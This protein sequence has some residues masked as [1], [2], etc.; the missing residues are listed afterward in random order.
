MI[1]PK[2]NL[3]GFQLSPENQVKM[4]AMRKGHEVST[5]FEMPAYKY[6]R[7]FAGVQATLAAEEA[8]KSKHQDSSKADLWSKDVMGLGTA[9]EALQGDTTSAREAVA[10]LLSETLD[11]NHKKSN[12]SYTRFSVMENIEANAGSNKTPGSEGN[13]GISLLDRYELDANSDQGSIGDHPIRQHVVF[14]E[15][16]QTRFGLVED[17]YTNVGSWDSFLDDNSAK[18]LGNIM[19]RRMLEGTKNSPA[20]RNVVEWDQL[21]ITG[22]DVDSVYEQM[23]PRL[24]ADM[25]WGSE[26]EIQRGLDIQRERIEALGSSRA[27]RLEHWKQAGNL[28]P[29][30]DTIMQKAALRNT[31]LFGKTGSSEPFDQSVKAVMAGMQKSG[32]FPAGFELLW[33]SYDDTALKDGF[34]NLWDT[35]ELPGWA[36]TEDMLGDLDMYTRETFR[37]M[38]RSAELARDA[39]LFK[40]RQQE[41]SRAAEEAHPFYNSYLSAEDADNILNNF[42]DRVNALIPEW[43]ILPSREKWEVVDDFVKELYPERDN[44]DIATY[45]TRL[46]ENRGGT[47]FSPE[48]RD[49]DREMMEILSPGSTR[50]EGPGLFAGL[51]DDQVRDDVY[52]FSRLFAATTTDEE[53]DAR[54]NNP[55]GLRASLDTA[56]TIRNIVL[57]IADV[58]ESGKPI[59]SDSLVK[60][61]MTSLYGHGSAYPRN[62]QGMLMAWKDMA[63]MTDPRWEAGMREAIHFAV[64]TAPELEN[65]LMLQQNP[66]LA[67]EEYML[68]VFREEYG[69]DYV[70]NS[71]EDLHNLVTDVAFNHKDY[72]LNRNYDIMSK[73]NMLKK[74]GSDFYAKEGSAT[75]LEKLLNN[76]EANSRGGSR[77]WGESILA[78]TFF[79][80]SSLI[81]NEDTAEG[82]QVIDNGNIHIGKAWLKSSQEELGQE[83]SAEYGHTDRFPEHLINRETYSI[84]WEGIQNAEE[85]RV[86][87]NFLPR[88][89]HENN[90]TGG[91]PVL[92]ELRTLINDGIVEST[93]PATKE[94]SPE[95]HASRLRVWLATNAIVTLT[96]MAVKDKTVGKTIFDRVLGG[97]EFDDLEKTTFKALGLW[98]TQGTDWRAALDNDYKKLAN[99]DDFGQWMAN[100]SKQA[101]KLFG[102]LANM[103]TGDNDVNNKSQGPVFGFDS[104]AWNTFRAGQPSHD[105]TSIQAYM[106]RPEYAGLL[107]SLE[108]AGIRIP[109]SAIEDA[110][111]TDRGN[112]EHTYTDAK[113]L[114]NTL[115]PALTDKRK[116]DHMNWGTSQF[117]LVQGLYSLIG[118]PDSKQLA[119]AFLLADINDGGDGLTVG[120]L[121]MLVDTASAFKRGPNTAPYVGVGVTSAGQQVIAADGAG[122]Y[123]DEVTNELDEGEDLLTE[124]S[125]HYW[126]NTPYSKAHPSEWIR[127][128]EGFANDVERN[129]HPGKYASRSEEFQENLKAW[130]WRGYRDPVGSVIGSI[131]SW[132]NP[133]YMDNNPDHA[134]YLAKSSNPFKTMIT[135]NFTNEKWKPTWESLGFKSS[136]EWS[137]WF[138]TSI[139]EP[140]VQDVKEAED[141]GLLDQDTS[142]N[143]EDVH[144][145]LIDR[146]M[147]AI[148]K[149]GGVLGQGDPKY[150]LFG[151]RGMLSGELVYGT[152]LKRYGQGTTFSL[153]NTSRRE[154]QEGGNA[155]GEMILT[156]T[157]L[158][159][160]N[161]PMQG[162]IRL[163]FTINDEDITSTS[164][165]WNQK[166]HGFNES[167]PKPTIDLPF[168]PS[169][170][171]R[172]PL[173]IHGEGAMPLSNVS[174]LNKEDMDRELDAMVS[175]DSAAAPAATAAPA[176]AAKPVDTSG[177]HDRNVERLTTVGDGVSGALGLTTRISGSSQML[178]SSG[179]KTVTLKRGTPEYDEAL[180]E[181]GYNPDAH[182]FTPEG[183]KQLLLWSQ[184]ATFEGIDTKDIKDIVFTTEYL[185]VLNADIRKQY[186]QLSEKDADLL[187]MELKMWSGRNPINLGTHA[188]VWRKLAKGDQVYT[189]DIGVQTYDSRTGAPETLIQGERGMRH[190]VVKGDSLG[191][192]ARN[193]KMSIK[194]L[195]HWNP[196]IKDPNTIK[197][198]Q[199]VYIPGEELRQQKW[200]RDTANLVIQFEG[201]HK[202]TEKVGK[203]K[204]F[205]GGR[206]HLFDGDTR[207]RAAFNRAFKDEKP[208]LVYNDYFTGK[209]T[210]TILQ[211]DA[212]FEEDLSD[213]TKTAIKH[214]NTK[215]KKDPEP[216]FL[217]EDLSPNLRK[218]LVAATYRGSWTGSPQAAADVRAGNWTKAAKE[219]LDYGQ[220]KD[221][222]NDPKSTIKGIIPRMD[223][224]SK[225]LAE[226][227]S[228]QK[229]LKH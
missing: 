106:Q 101:D 132:A 138:F 140:Y 117:A 48:L 215:R 84:R 104:Y 135:R 56:A 126:N 210:L 152:N 198:D 21:G 80:P 179:S 91:S 209:K 162:K 47:T 49:A 218:Y 51:T 185:A 111:W 8:I 29:M 20:L 13:L 150:N 71:Y 35:Y 86:L 174:T 180:K 27:E 172:V 139:V 33:D 192:I 25:M 229:E 96:N 137:E 120:E 43:D 182:I 168:D 190:V 17:G 37:A 158:T 77:T 191:A 68:T 187:I 52:Y 214:T 149:G 167:S 169:D 119:S 46:H 112:Y 115:T 87:F 129:T 148:Q 145:N 201:Y 147:V 67:W 100:K 82:R 92:T 212:L 93:D 94:D 23:E 189:Q 226:E 171:T 54:F 170:A 36:T 85:A 3:D 134:E 173:D 159:G 40:E 59:I 105:E 76:Q 122:E 161:G 62:S 90:I 4:E 38:D 221:T 9:S 183:E 128:G 195:L 200:E 202:K 196:G 165:P 176:A 97:G 75:A 114:K 41:I 186:P 164:L 193:N 206:G 99:P 194:E 220:Y 55:L 58:D 113:E 156:T 72:G 81:G 116:E 88:V 163:P 70:L 124:A 125:R 50:E 197:I 207:S 123:F 22:D 45:I 184:V 133:W 65:N 178:G 142:P 1:P 130:T 10:Y 60:N 57:S 177:L 228:Y 175:K 14:D 110:P 107:K 83:R 44:P 219:F 16:I 12:N 217:W 2:N 42:N 18:Q 154:M 109:P 205:T 5:T 144:L 213:K 216:L 143:K 188:A 7:V 160:I 222:K 15:P 102:L 153:D 227:A 118:D 199:Q 32:E 127:L 208:P 61:I 204:W 63:D 34:R 157:N 223:A 211:A 166:A 66:T 64:N 89:I 155:G 79:G 181:K 121:T 151:I 98:L 31:K 108:K 74:A 224:V 69:D 203:E 28:E 6:G 103:V 141:A 73:Y 131:F 11:S 30:I 95:G 136:D 24:V 26:E 146:L 19:R 225:A 78:G 53:W 39:I